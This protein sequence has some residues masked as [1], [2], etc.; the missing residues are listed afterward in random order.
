MARKGIE[1]FTKSDFEAA[2]PKHKTTGQPLWIEAGFSLGE[3]TYIIQPFEKKPYGILV[4]S[5]VGVDG[6][7]KGCGE[8]SIRGRIVKITPKDNGTPVYSF[9]GGKSQRWVTRQTGWQSRMI[10]MLRKLANQLKWCQPCPH[11]GETLTPYTTKTKTNGNKG[12]GFVRCDSSACCPDGKKSKSFYWTDDDDKEP[13][14]P[15]PSLTA[16]LPKQEQGKQEYL[17]VR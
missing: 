8:D 13:I 11:C 6:T 16:Q 10:D 9:H 7:N 12:K 17:T 15:P 14:A 1:H 2:L 3:F 5:S 4:R